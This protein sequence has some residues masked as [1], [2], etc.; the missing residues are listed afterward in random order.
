MK[1]AMY[2][3]A[4]YVDFRMVTGVSQIKK[5]I[6]KEKVWLRLLFFWFFSFAFS[7]QNE[8]VTSNFNQS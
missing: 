2:W 1:S 7:K 6:L 3:L 4:A 8:N 5:I